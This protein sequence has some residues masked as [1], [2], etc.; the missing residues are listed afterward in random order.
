MNSHDNPILA[1]FREYI[2]EASDSSVKWSA[3]YWIVGI[4]EDES[5]NY[6]LTAA[7]HVFHAIENALGENPEGYGHMR[8][9]NI[10]RERDTQAQEWR[11]HAKRVLEK[12]AVY[13]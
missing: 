11:D 9:W 12:L 6:E 3:E 7:A 4:D 2:A 5:G 13:A 10:E 1:D 8:A